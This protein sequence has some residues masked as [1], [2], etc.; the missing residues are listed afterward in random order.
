MPLTNSQYDSIQREYYEIRANN[1]RLHDK[2]LEEINEL[3]PEYRKLEEEIGE[4]SFQAAAKNLSGETAGTDTPDHDFKTKLRS[5]KN[6]Q[7]E[8]LISLGKP[9]DYLDPVYTCPN[10]RDKGYTG[11]VKCDCFKKRELELLYRDSNLKNMAGGYTFE[12]FDISLYSDKDIDKITGK[13]AKEYA[14]T[15]LEA[16]KDL[17]SN[18]D[19][20]KGNLF[21]YGNTGLGKTMLST[22]IANA[23]IRTTHSVVYV[24]ATELVNKLNTFD[25][26]VESSPL[27][28]CDLLIIDDLGTEYL[29]DVSASKLFYCLNERL[30]RGRSCVISTNLDLANIQD[31]YSERIFS[32]IVSSYKVIKLYGE[33]LRTARFR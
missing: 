21:L 22:C 7:N 16:A 14:E 23:L 18:I 4:V 2:R 27:L 32:R 12:D 8:L 24:T 25:E 6:K 15:A 17:V 13:T 30:L 19:T 33:D 31:R 29:S 20:K 10:C 5:L 1:K 9:A 26:D 11:T 3:T 28:E